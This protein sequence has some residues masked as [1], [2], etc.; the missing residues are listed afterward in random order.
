M[1][2]VS[3]SSKKPSA[4]VPWLLW[5]T[6]IVPLVLAVFLY[7]SNAWSPINRVN[8]GELYIPPL[9]IE[10]LGVTDW[11]GNPLDV[12]AEGKWQI[13]LIAQRY[14]ETLLKETLH[15]YRQ[16]H[17]TLGKNQSRV[18]RNLLLL[19]TD[20][21]PVEL[22]DEYP[23]LRLISAKR[24]NLNAL[25]DSVPEGAVPPSQPGVLVCDPLG[26]IMLSYSLEQIGKPMLKDLKKLLK[27]SNIG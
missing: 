23:N 5:S 10:T 20:S 19:E 9:S 13:I 11:Q 25:L 7:F 21:Y 16:F 8:E 15:W 17:K 24:S 26:N 22:K 4:W 1:S 12:L 14:D 3:D 27:L 6:A 2:K 18:E